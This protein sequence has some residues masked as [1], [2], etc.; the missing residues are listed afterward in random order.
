MRVRT[1]IV[2]VHYTKKTRS[3][4]SAITGF[5]LSHSLNVTAVLSASLPLRTGFFAEVF[6]G[7]DSR[8]SAPRH[9]PPPH[10]G[11]SC[12]CGN[13]F[14]LCSDLQ[15]GKAKQLEGWQ[16]QLLDNSNKQ[17]LISAFLV[18][19]TKFS[20]FLLTAFSHGQNQVEQK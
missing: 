14:I 20:S 3:G 5:Q 2:Y 10:M 8:F 1:Y 9:P 15:G 13:H 6:C 17:K 7:F 19:Q 4:H 18:C 12:C 16:T 11:T